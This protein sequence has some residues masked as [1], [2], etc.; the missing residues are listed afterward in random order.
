MAVDPTRRGALGGALGGT[1]AAA[2]VS[3]AALA[4][5]LAGP[6]SGPPRTFVLVHGAW[7]GGWCWRDVRALLEAAGH[8]VVC[9]TL[10][11]L[12]ERAHLRTPVPG[13]AMHVRDVCAVIEAEELEQIMLVGHSYGGMVI[14]GV[15]DALA[16]RIAALVYL[17]AALPADGQSMITQSPGI[18][19]ELAAATEAQ[20]RQLAP[21]GIWMAPLPPSVLGVPE[22]NQQ[23]TAWLTRRLTPHPLPTW[24]E[25]LRLANGG[26]SHL[27]RTYVLCTAPILAQA[28]FAAHAAR[29]RSG[30]AGPGWTYRELA[31]GHDAMVTD[32]QGTAALLLEAAASS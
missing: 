10:T 28:S 4:D 30:E 24:T 11:G 14:T 8:R 26:G 15:A 17:D 21:D 7:H 1:L 20:L 6:A 3:S 25:P 13:L 29:V 22:D 31:T 5:P 16:S 19:P 2:V 9:Q 18:T 12:G 27:P 23:A 32:P